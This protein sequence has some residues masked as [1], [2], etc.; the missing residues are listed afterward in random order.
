MVAAVATV[1]GL[2]AGTLWDNSETAYGEVARE[3]LLTHDWIVMHLNGAPWFVQPPLYF[4]IAAALARVLGTTAFALRLPSALATIAMGA[5]VGAAVARTSSFRAG[6]LSAVVLS[7][8]LMQAVVGRLAIMDALL[9]ALVA[10][11]IFAG[12]AALRTG[13]RRAWIGAWAA[14]ALGILAKGLV[15]PTLVVLVLAPWIVWETIAGTRIKAPKPWVVIA[16][17]AVGAAILLPWILALDSRAGGFAFRELVGHY[18]VGRYLGTIENQ[19]GPVWYYVPVVILGFFPW[20]AFLVPAGVAA[21]GEAAR[22]R[23]GSL[24]RLALVWAVVPFVFFSFAHTK[25]PNYI[26]LELPALAILVGLWFDAVVDRVD[27]RVALAFAALVPVTLVLVAV[28]VSAFSHD[29][30]LT[31]ELDALRPA[32][33]ALGGAMLAGSLACFGFL[34]LRRLSLLAPFV[35]GASGIAVVLAIALV[36]EP[37]VERYKPVPKLASQ[38][39]RLRRPGDSVETVGVPGSNALVFYTRPGVIS[40]DDAAPLRCE[41]SRAFIVASIRASL[42]PSAL[43]VASAGHDVLYLM[44][45]VG[46]RRRM[47]AP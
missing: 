40:L 7:S 34:L 18:T 22:D 38:I 16:G 17:F 14:I 12:Y 32:F 2:G 25:L 35:L 46:E 39:D 37:I 13:E 30:R 41:G 43:V 5:L 44:P 27:R 8:S 23:G 31:P 9:D 21:L 24:V 29:N 28:A 11:A 47:N 45:C 42:P 20:V 33:L 1:P 36:G 3:V 15:A 10:G 6:V 4:W 26:A 19:S